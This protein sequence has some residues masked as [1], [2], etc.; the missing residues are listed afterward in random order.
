MGRGGGIR[1]SADSLIACSATDRRN[2][3]TVLARG[4]RSPYVG[5]WIIVCKNPPAVPVF[6]GS[7]TVRQNNWLWW[8][9]FNAPYLSWYGAGLYTKQF[10]QQCKWHTHNLCLK[11]ITGYNNTSWM[12]T[13]W[14]P[15]SRKHEIIYFKNKN[16]EERK[17]GKCIFLTRCCQVN[18]ISR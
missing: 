3:R 4:P 2:T 16:K 7:Y 5:P 11:I 17:K 10:K 12:I 1:R 14:I 9:C 6:T 15:I 13:C 8:D 18:D